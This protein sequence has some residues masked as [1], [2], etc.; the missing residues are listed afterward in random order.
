MS[1]CHC[2]CA[3]K[4]ATTSFLLS[5]QFKICY[6]LAITLR[7]ILS[8]SP[9]LFFSLV[10]LSPPEA[11]S[12]DTAPTIKHGIVTSIEGLENSLSGKMTGT[13]AN[14]ASMN[15]RNFC[16]HVPVMEHG[17]FPKEACRG[18]WYGILEGNWLSMAQVHEGHAG[19]F[20]PMGLVS[21]RPLGWL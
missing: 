20:R 8:V 3:D 7:P 19:W 13:Q 14:K 15:K 2:L 9:L 5:S 17:N 11:S 1:V 4:F 6:C 16:K 21:N 12:F 10:C 18:Q